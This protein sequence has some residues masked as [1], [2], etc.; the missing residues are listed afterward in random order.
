MNKE[1]SRTQ[2]LTR[3]AIM[4]A[5]A[6]VFQLGGFHQFITGP[7]VNMVLYFSALVLG[8]G[9]GVVIGLLTPLIAFLVGILKAPLVLI[10]PFIMAGNA[11]LVII[12]YLLKEKSIFL[13]V[14]VASLAKF[15]LLGGAVRLIVDVPE[16]VGQAFFYPQLVTA[17]AGGVLAWIVYKIMV[18][19]DYIEEI[20]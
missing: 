19:N 8:A 18:A 17:L 15:L 12:F 6:L 3:T 7:V 14:I 13:G 5:I 16:K 10:I 20:K 2:W 1:K 11:L 4:L 9:S